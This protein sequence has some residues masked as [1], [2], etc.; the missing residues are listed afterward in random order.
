M[1]TFRRRVAAL[2]VG[3]AVALVLALVLMA[4]PRR[5]GRLAVAPVVGGD[6]ALAKTPFARPARA[7][8]HGV[9]HHPP[10]SCDEGDGGDGEGDG[11][12]VDVGSGVDLGLDIDVAGLGIRLAQPVA[13]HHC[14]PPPTTTTTVPVTTTTAPSPAPSVPPTTAAPLSPP[15]EAP[16]P[17]P[18]PPRTAP[19]PPS[20]STSTTTTTAPPVPLVP[21]SP[22]R[23]A[24]TAT[25][26]PQ[27]PAPGE[28]ATVTIEVRNDGAGP[29]DDLVLSDEVA[30]TTELRGASSSV[31][32][33]RVSG[34]TAVC[35]LGVLEPGETAVVRVR[36]KV[37]PEP[38]S[39]TLA[40]HLTLSTGAS[41]ELATRS[42]STLVAPRVSS[43]L[44][45]LDLPGPTVT[46]VM[47][48]TF[49]L[50]ARSG[51]SAPSVVLGRRRR[52]R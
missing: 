4:A 12:D 9:G 51:S 42:I 14:P 41:A 28:W 20:T 31:G 33:C 39:S 46:V 35:P 29:V 40:Q 25:F 6:V 19:P 26:D 43:G 24:L 50:A 52:Q 22:P 1:G 44:A 23:L 11:I 5:P 18:R 49:V 15:A 36:V 7:L 27:R 13:H 48:V 32:A 47:L 17:P 30:R 21:P 3:L 16:P 8:A 10:P 2:G 34:R 38:A 37:V 45:L